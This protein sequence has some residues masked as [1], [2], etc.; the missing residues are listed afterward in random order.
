MEGAQ[1]GVKEQ[2]GLIRLD[3][4]QHTALQVRGGGRRLGDVAEER[5]LSSVV[6]R[7]EAAFIGN[8]WVG[9]GRYCH[10]QKEPGMSLEIGGRRR[11]G[12][13]KG[14]VGATGVG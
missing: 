12:R 2:L 13:E 8:S 5:G 1:A 9:E 11:G 4:Q 14:E 7:G 6:G 3:L 10:L